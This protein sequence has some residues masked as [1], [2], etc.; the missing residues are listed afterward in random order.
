[1]PYKYEFVPVSFSGKLDRQF[2]E[3]EGGHKQYDDNDSRGV[4]AELLPSKKESVLQES[5][6]LGKTNI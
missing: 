1:M 5:K 3:R 2:C 4:G 6:D